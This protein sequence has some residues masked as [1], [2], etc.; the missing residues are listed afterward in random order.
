MENSQTAILRK[1]I[2]EHIKTL[3]CT[4]EVKSFEMFLQKIIIFEEGRGD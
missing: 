3:V 1:W 2:L 4:F